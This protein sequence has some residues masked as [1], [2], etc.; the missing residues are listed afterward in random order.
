MGHESSGRGDEMVGDQTELSVV[1]QPNGDDLD[2]YERLLDDAMDGDQTLFARQDGV[3]AAWAVVDHVLGNVTPVYEY[4]PGIVGTP[5]GEPADE[6][7]S[8]EWHN[9]APSGP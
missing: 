5:A 7:G 3:E 1:H 4:A 6:S 8:R 2:A 9:P